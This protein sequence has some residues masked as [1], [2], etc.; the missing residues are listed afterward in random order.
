MSYDYIIILSP[1]YLSISFSIKTTNMIDFV[2]KGIIF[3]FYVRVFDLPYC[4]HKYFYRNKMLWLYI[5]L[6][7]TRNNEE[8]KWCRDFRDEVSDIDMK[9]FLPDPNSRTVQVSNAY[10]MHVAGKS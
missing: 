7:I 6:Y 2:N 9:I 8:G 5:W 4:K 10:E 3:A 1:A